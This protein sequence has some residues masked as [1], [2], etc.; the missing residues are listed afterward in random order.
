[1]LTGNPKAKT[2]DIVRITY[3]GRLDDGTQFDSSEGR[4]PL[5]I[6]LGTGEVI[7]GL[8]AHLLGMEPGTRSTVTIPQE[9]AYGPRREEAVQ[10]IERANV[11]PEL[12]LR[13]GARMQARTATGD[14]LPITVLDFDDNVVKLDTNHPLAGK[15][16]VFDVELLEIVRAA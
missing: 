13:R 3:T 5:Q 7:P 9:A 4:E 2:G 16:L 6:T 15:D 10:T 11:P 12:N 8:E 14:V 1:M